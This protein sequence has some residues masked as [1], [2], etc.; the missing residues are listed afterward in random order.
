V[1][2]VTAMMRASE[3]REHARRCRSMAKTM[4]D[5][6]RREMLSIAETWERL[7]REREREREHALAEQAQDERA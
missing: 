6:H 3:C 2:R 4:A 1:A 5:E 7:A